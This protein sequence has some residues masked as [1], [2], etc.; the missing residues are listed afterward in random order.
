MSKETGTYVLQSCTDTKDIAAAPV[1]ASLE[2]AAALVWV[3]SEQDQPRVK[4]IG[5]GGKER[6]NRAGLSWIW[7]RLKA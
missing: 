5:V 3:H 7:S 2:R 4:V 1:P 6:G